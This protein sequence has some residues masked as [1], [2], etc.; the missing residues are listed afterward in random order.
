MGISISLVALVFAAYSDVVGHEFVDFDDHLYI[1]SNPHVS[2]GLTWEGVKYAFTGPHGGNWHPLT[3][4]SHMLDCEVFGADLSRAGPHVLVNVGLHALAA[5]LLFLA[6]RALCG[7]C[8]PS[9]FVAALFALHPLRVESVAWASARKDVLSGVFFMLSLLAY[10][11]YARASRIGRYLLVLVVLGLGLMAKPTLVTVPFVF[12]L[13]DV[14]PL[15]RWC[16]SRDGAGDRATH[17]NT[18]PLGAIP[19]IVEKAPLLALSLFSGLMTWSAQDVA[20]RSLE[21]LPLE[22]R[23]INAPV[24]YVVYLWKTLWPS[25][26]APF[27]PHPGLLRADAPL[28]WQA[29]G[30]VGTVILVTFTTILWRAVRRRPY[31]LV[32]WLWYLGMLLP[33]IGLLQVG[34]QS[35]AD[36][37]TYLPGIGIAIM[38][39]WLITDLAARA[40]LWQRTAV[41]SGALLLLPMLLATRAQVSHWRSGR[42]LFEHTLDVTE[43]NYLA[44][45]NLGNALLREGLVQDAR[46]HYEQALRIWP[47]YPDARSN[48]ALAHIKLGEEL[49][50][51]ERWPDAAAHF[52]LAL[53][54]MPDFADAYFYLGNVSFRLGRLDE[55]EAHYRQALQ[56][57]PRHADA[58]CNLGIVLEG[59]GRTGEAAEHYR[60]ALEIDPTFE[61]ALR[62]LARVTG[63]AEPP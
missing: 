21:A 32:G 47:A 20:T 19:L 23:L 48:L 54:L 43:G 53:R 31:L 24:S 60:A 16:R 41:V 5:V 59:L 6:L 39:V 38:L 8:V 56:V 58:H 22:W 37:Y 1:L 61:R 55:A 46:D 44:H 26:M 25:G 42:A 30:A 34:M 36:R 17:A 27:Y 4:L 35:R 63:R 57:M 3:T 13:L 62:G 2:R 14:W 15:R 28:T 52:E 12:L 40:R 50:S 11:R 49:L 10:G 9:A 29:A 51:H 33:M 18:E 45:N 7:G